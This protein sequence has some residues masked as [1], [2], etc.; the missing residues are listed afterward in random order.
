MYK[1][2]NDRWMYLNRFLILIFFNIDKLILEKFA[3]LSVQSIKVRSYKK[4]NYYVYVKS[5]I[6]VNKVI[7]IKNQIPNQGLCL[8]RSHGNDL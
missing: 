3:F 7:L 6:L 2:I 4:C 5:G 1:L 8:T